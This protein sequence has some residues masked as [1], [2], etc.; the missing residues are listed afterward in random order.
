MVQRDSP[1]INV[2]WRKRHYVPRRLMERNPIEFLVQCMRHS[3]KFQYHEKQKLNYETK[4]QNNYCA[5]LGY[6]KVGNVM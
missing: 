1:S 3:T 5:F 2:S 6:V 4:N